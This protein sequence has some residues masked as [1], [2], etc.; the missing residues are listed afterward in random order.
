V[1]SASLWLALA[2]GERFAITPAGLVLGRAPTS[3]IVLSSTKASRRQAIVVASATGVT[4]IVLGQGHTLVNDVAVERERDLV[5]GDRLQVPGLT[6]TVIA[7]SAAFTTVN[8]SW[9]VQTRAGSLF[10]VAR[11][12]FVVGGSPGADVRVADWPAEVL[13]FLVTDVLHVSASVPIAVNGHGLAAGDVEAAPAGTT[14]D[15][16]DERY[17]VVAG[18]ALGDDSTTGATMV[19]VAPSAAEVEFLSRGGRLSLTIARKRE[20]V[21][22]AEKR[23][24]LVATLLRPPL[25]YRPGD[26]VPDEVVLPRLWPGRVMSRV[27]LNT[28]LH[29]T[30]H[31]LI[32]AGLDGA[33]LLP[34][35]QGGN[36]T[37]FTLMAGAI[38]RFE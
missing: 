5:D 18:G 9:V 23:C 1:P 12:P 17:T 37:R 22:L 6:A 7:G 38:V 4:L 8:T 34:R 3:D 20:V 24:E 27:D 15:Y 2:G 11:S 33:L 13:R 35:A 28:L 14:I 26:F 30:R 10:G 25:P 32:A 19:A 31:D 36:A 29:R 21:Y 16:R